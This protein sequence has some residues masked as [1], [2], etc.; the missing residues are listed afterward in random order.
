M[1]VTKEGTVDSL[2]TGGTAAHFSY[3]DGT[4]RL[5]IFNALVVTKGY[6]CQNEKSSFPVFH[7]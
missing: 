6:F 7:L 3:R 1:A 4:D 5:C 2:F